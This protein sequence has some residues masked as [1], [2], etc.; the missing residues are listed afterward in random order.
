MGP[1]HL[2][3]VARLEAEVQVARLGLAARVAPPEV[4]ERVVLLEALVERAVPREAE[5]Q[6]ALPVLEVQVAPPVLE[7]QVAL[8]VQVAPPEA[9]AAHQAHPVAWVDL[10]GERVEQVWLG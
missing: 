8:P 10:A 9:Q 1:L 7:V 6:V 5:A 3:R 2:A 4:E